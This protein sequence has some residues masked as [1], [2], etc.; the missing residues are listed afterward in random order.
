MEAPRSKQESSVIVRPQEHPHPANLLS[1]GTKQTAAAS[2]F[3][4]SNTQPGYPSAG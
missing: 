3:L 2:A 1:R 4:A